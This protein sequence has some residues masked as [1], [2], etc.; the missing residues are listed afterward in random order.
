MSRRHTEAEITALLDKAQAMAAQGRL[1]NDIA[2]TLGVSLMTYHR[3]RKAHAARHSVSPAVAA[4]RTSVIERDRSNPMSEL[5]LENTRL[6]RLVADLLLEKMKL[7]ET[8]EGRGAFHRTAG[9]A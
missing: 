7:E 3:W 4:D 9:G 1:Q 2:E 6:R 5:Y 8:L